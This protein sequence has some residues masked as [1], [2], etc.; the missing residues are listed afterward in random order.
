MFNSQRLIFIIPTTSL[1]DKLR[2]KILSPVELQTSKIYSTNN[3]TIKRDPISI[4]WCL[5]PLSV[6]TRMYYIVVLFD[7]TRAL[8]L[9]RPLPYVF[10]C[11]LIFIVTE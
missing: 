4:V 7:T 11:P 5:F 3:S 9:F 10:L 8:L 2:E 1:L 6:Q